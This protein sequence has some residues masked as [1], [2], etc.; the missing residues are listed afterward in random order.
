MIYTQK[1]T[2]FQN[3]P[4]VFFWKNEKNSPK[5]SMTDTTIHICAEL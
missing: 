3:I 1:F 2:I 4:L 5:K